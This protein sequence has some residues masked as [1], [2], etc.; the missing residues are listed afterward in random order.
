MLEVRL[1]LGQRQPLERS[2][3]VETLSIWAVRYRRHEP[4]AAFQHFNAAT[5][6]LS[7]QLHVISTNSDLNNH[8]WLASGG[9]SQWAGPSQQPWHREQGL[10]WGQNTY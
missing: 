1:P 7:F 9:L 6:D 8:T 5:E 10:A 3:T 4:P 2:V